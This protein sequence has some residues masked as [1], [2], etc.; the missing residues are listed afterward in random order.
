[1]KIKYLCSVMERR[2]GKGIGVNPH[3]LHYHN[4]CIFTSGQRF[5]ARAMMGIRGATTN[6]FELL[7]D[8]NVQLF[9]SQVT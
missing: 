6:V 5:G 9:T 4:G 2:T 3:R 8:A 1:M 7:S